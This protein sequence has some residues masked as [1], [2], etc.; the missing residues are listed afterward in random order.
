MKKFISQTDNSLKRKK[1][2]WTPKGRQ[3]EDSYFNQVSKLF[4]GSTGLVDSVRSLQVKF[5]SEVL[6]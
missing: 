2:R 1:R 5:F 4:V 6:F 3:V